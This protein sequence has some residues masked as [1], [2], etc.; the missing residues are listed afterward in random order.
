MERPSILLLPRYPPLRLTESGE[1]VAVDPALLPALP[2]SDI[3]SLC[4]VVSLI[5]PVLVRLRVH[6]P[7]EALGGLASWLESL[8]RPTTKQGL[9]DLLLRLRFPVQ[10]PSLQDFRYV[11]NMGGAGGTACIR[12][13]AR[14]ILTTGNS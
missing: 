12:A 5:G 8:P 3:R 7:G 13:G 2:W 14:I 11:K 4:P 1:I 10:Y 9:A 6:H